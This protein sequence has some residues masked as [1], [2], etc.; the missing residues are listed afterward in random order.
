MFLFRI[1]TTLRPCDP[2]EFFF[3]EDYFFTS[4]GLAGFEL[5]G[6][7]FFIVID[8]DNSESTSQKKSTPRILTDTIRIYGDD[9]KGP[10]RT[11]L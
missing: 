10:I 11:A 7:V 9:E 2:T 4:N 6:N 1:A 5:P 3:I 8:T